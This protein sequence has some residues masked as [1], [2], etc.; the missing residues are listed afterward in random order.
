MVKDDMTERLKAKFDEQKIL[1]KIDNE[2]IYK[3]NN[4]KQNTRNYLYNK[5][6]SFE[7]QF[8]H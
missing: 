1:I 3:L 4:S 6:D 5:I 2:K 7:L 8:N